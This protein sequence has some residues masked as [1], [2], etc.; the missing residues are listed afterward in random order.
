MGILIHST[1][2]TSSSISAKA[3]LATLGVEALL[4]SGTEGP[5]G[6]SLTDESS[7]WTLIAPFSCL[8]TISYVDPVSGSCVLRLPET[9]K[10][11]FFHSLE[12]PQTCEE[13]IRH[14]LCDPTARLVQVNSQPA[15]FIFSS[16]EKDICGP[17]TGL[18]IRTDE[19]M[20]CWGV[21]S[22]MK[23][24]DKVHPL[25]ELDSASVLLLLKEKDL[26]VFM[27]FTSHLA[28]P[29]QPLETNL[30][31]HTCLLTLAAPM[32]VLKYLSRGFGWS[33]RN[34][35]ANLIID[36]P[37]LTTQ[38]GY[39]DFREVYELAAKRGIAVTLAYIPFN[40]RRGSDEI[41]RFFRKASDR[42]AICIH[43]CNHTRS[44]FGD[45]DSGRISA[46]AFLASDRMISFSERTG[47]PHTKI[48]VFPQGVFSSQALG[49]LKRHN[50]TAAV[51][52]ELKDTTGE[53]RVTIKDM[54]QPAITCY[55]GFPLFLRRKISDGIGNFAFDLLLD[56]P[57]LIVAHHDDFFSDMS[58]VWQLVDAINR[59][60][61]PPEWRPLEDIMARTAL[62]R[63]L[64]NNLI[65]LKI[66]SRTADLKNIIDVPTENYLRVIKDEGQPE[67]INR[68]LVGQRETEWH[69]EEGRI[70]VDVGKHSEGSMLMVLYRQDEY[71]ELPS[72][73]LKSHIGIWCRRRLCEF[74]DNYVSKSPALQ[75]MVQFVRNLL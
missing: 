7:A 22:Q 62:S 2:P 19:E 41:I 60:P 71:L 66:Y 39:I 54:L 13:I 51:N 36:D 47:I 11:V 40:Y 12:S 16:N 4:E 34:N 38:Y 25:I 45:T 67:T 74:R 20:A 42:I 5:L 15:D 43:G 6:S 70:I 73:Q 37:P 14:L 63:T 55:D 21:V 32:M 23:P 61:N 59:L 18:T 72:P 30:D 31:I 10:T 65:E 58:P 27:L 52:T 64:G 1:T 57:C 75:N 3:M 28:N 53:N 49:V 69:I 50:F 9:I 8:E 17:L 35:Y 68:V 48:M 26:D 56:K 24:S 46:L 33:A 44:E 29:D